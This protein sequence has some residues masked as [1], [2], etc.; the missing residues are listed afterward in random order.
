MCLRFHPKVPHILFACDA[1][2]HI[3]QYNLQD[4][5]SSHVITGL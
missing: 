1:E 5:T 2:G 3:Y 4:G